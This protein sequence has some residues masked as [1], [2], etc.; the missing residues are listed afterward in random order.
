MNFD[1]NHFISLSVW[2]DTWN[3][4]RMI[5]DWVEGEYKPVTDYKLNSQ[6]I[7]FT[8]A[9]NATLFRLKWVDGIKNG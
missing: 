7:S 1:E 5:M 2:G 8:E 3:E 6:G 9:Q 4:Y